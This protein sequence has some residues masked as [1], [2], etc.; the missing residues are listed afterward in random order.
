MTY[1]QINI[2]SKEEIPKIPMLI[3]N[4][5]QVFKMNASKDSTRR[6]IS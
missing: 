5:L 3:K 6:R 2:E 4:D 1:T